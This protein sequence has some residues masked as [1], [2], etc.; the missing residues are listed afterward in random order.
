MDDDP[1][2][3]FAPSAARHGI[4]RD[5][6]QYVIGHCQ[7]PLYAPDEDRDNADLVLFLGPDPKGVL[8]EVVAIEAED[9]GLVVIH[10]MRLRRRY[11][12]ACRWV[13]GGHR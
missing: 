8:L 7:N 13:I 1:H 4:D 11:R 12:E 3:E 2:L 6:V 9:G 5:R 10:A